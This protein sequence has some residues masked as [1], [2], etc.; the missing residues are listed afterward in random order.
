MTND[1]SYKGLNLNILVTGSYGNDIFN[2]SRVEM[3]GM[4]TASNQLKEVLD[5]WRVPGQITDVPKSNEPWNNRVSSRWIEDGSYIKIKNITLS[6]NINTE[7]LKKINISRIQPY[8]TL[9]NFFT[10]TKYS[11]YDPEVSQ[12]GSATSLGIDWG[13]YPHVKTVVFGLNIDF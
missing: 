3:V 4:G 7:K 12:W 6:Y 13:T 2:A 5:R 11:G 8:V 9:Q 10:F 1:L